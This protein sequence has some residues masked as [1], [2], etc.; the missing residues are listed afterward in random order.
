LLVC[1][2]RKRAKL[3]STR[4]KQWRF[5]NLNKDSLSRERKPQNHYLYFFKLRV[6][7]RAGIPFTLKMFSLGTGIAEWIIMANINVGRR[8]RM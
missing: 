7:R 3:E 4:N 8:K 5:G 6:V 1:R 2:R